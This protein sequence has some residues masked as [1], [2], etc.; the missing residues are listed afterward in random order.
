VTPVTPVVTPGA[1][2]GV[3]RSV[4]P[5]RLTALQQTHAEQLAEIERL[6]AEVGLL[7]DENAVLKQRVGRVPMTAAERQRKRRS[8]I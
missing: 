2:P 7:R 5:S 1:E 3:P 4:A 8:K 6:T